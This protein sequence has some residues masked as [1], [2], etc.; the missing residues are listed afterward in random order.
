MS[1]RLCRFFFA[2]LALA[3][4]SLPA[5][6]WD[7]VTHAMISRRAIDQVR[8]PELKTFLKA[9][10]DV[11]QSGVWFP[12]WGHA[13]K[14]HGDHLHAEYLDAAWAYLQRPGVKAQPNYPV[15]LAHY[16]GAYGHVV[17]DRVLDATMKTYADEVGD[18][19]RDDME[20]GMLAIAGFHR[21]FRDFDLYVPKDDLARIYASAGYFGERRLNNDNLAAQM[22]RGMAHGEIQNRRLS[23]LSFLT[24]DW[25]R[26]KFPFATANIETAPG[27][28][29]DEAGAVAAAWEA[30]WARAH[31]RPASFFVYTVPG[32]HGEFRNRDPQSA[33]GRILIVT[34][35]RLD[36]RDLPQAA[37]HLR[38]GANEIAARIL[39]YIPEPGH[40]RDLAFLVQAQRP[41]QA[42]GR[43]T[44]DI[45][46]HD[47]AGVPQSLHLAFAMPHH[48][49]PFA[50]AKPEAR[51]MAFGLWLAAALLGLAGLL[52]GVA[53]MGKL[54]WA[55][56]RKRAPAAGGRL[57]Y[58]L[59]MAGKTAAIV[60]VA[61]GVWA[62]A[63]DG[64]WLI[65]FLRHH[66]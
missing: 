66:H 41:W 3:A 16:M 51:P 7:E 52:Y 47:S 50:K 29:N 4:V 9:H 8:V 54:A 12:D 10:Y 57:Y 56:I 26:R 61:A 49:A 48:P 24:A 43:Y 17:E 60:L 11:L 25:T 62:L 28:L 32:D 46:H 30:I 5:K 53:D 13:L 34:S 20:N 58:A 42:G 65:E 18:S 39:P 22:A 40:E 64:E 38:D 1:G 36:I 2:L 63:T 44:L 23:E 35:E 6:A 31:G 15:L 45:R 33:L 37:V 14:P 59:N 21:L 55:A 19:G 27:G